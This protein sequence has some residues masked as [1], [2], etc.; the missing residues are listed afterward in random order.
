MQLQAVGKMGD[1]GSSYRA[2]NICKDKLEKD[3]DEPW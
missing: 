3:N 1:T 2:L